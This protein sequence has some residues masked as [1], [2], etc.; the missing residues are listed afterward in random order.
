MKSI[1]KTVLAVTFFLSFSAGAQSVLI[2]L[3]V[4]SPDGKS[5]AFN[6]QGDIWTMDIT[7]Q[8][9]K[10]ITIHEGYDTKPFWSSTGKD[11][12]FISNRF[13]ND[14]IFVIGANGG[15][16]KR[17]TYHSTDD[18]IT[19]YT[20]EG[21]I[22]FSTERYYSQVEREP[23]IQHISDAGGTPELYLK[24]L[25]FDAKL[26]PNGKYVAFVRG[27]CRI[28]REAYR[29][30]AN[31]DIWLYD[32]TNDV[33]TQ[34]TN[35]DG[36]DFSP[37]W[38]DDNTIYFQ[39]SRS[40]K[41]NVHKLRIDG[42]G[43][44]IDAISAITNFKDSGIFSFS[45]SSNGDYFACVNG[46]KVFVSETNSNELKQVN[47]QIPT[48]YRFA[49]VKHESFSKGAG[50]VALSPNGKLSAFVIRGELFLRSTD[51][52]NAKTVNV[53]KSPYR[54]Q[55][56][57]WLNDS[58]IVFVSDRDGQN[59]LYL[60]KSGDPSKGLLESLKHDI[61][62]VT[63]TKGGE[64]H[65][66]ISP[67]GKSVA[68][69]LGRGKLIV[70]KINP[71]GK[72][73]DEIVLVDGWDTPD[74]VSWSP[75]SKWLAY[76]L[77]DLN[78]NQEVYIHRA[79]NRLKPVNVSMHP[80]R[81]REPI[82]SDDGKKLVFSSNRNNN[83]Y[84][85][86]FIWLNKSDS[87]KTAE[88]WKDEEINSS[89]KE[90]KDKDEKD[91]E[92]VIKPI[93]IDF[94]NIH[95][96]QIQVTNYVGGEFVRAISKDGKT[97]Y[98]TTGDGSR[99]DASVESDLFKIDW[100]G[101]N[102]KELTK[103]NARPSSLVL[104][105]KGTEI[106]LNL[107]SG[108][109]SKINLSNDKIESLPYNAK[110]DI[111]YIA[112]SEQIFEEAWKAIND[113]FYDPN[114]HGRDWNVLKEAYKPL[115]MK[116]STRTD[117]QN[118]FNWM[119]GQ[120]NASHMG[121]RSG[122]SR[123]ELE[124]ERT[125]LLGLQ[126]KPNNDGS[127]KVVNVV[128]NMPADKAMS[129]I[130]I[131]DVITSLNGTELTKNTNFYSLLEGTSDEKIY[132]ELIRNGKREEVIIRPKISNRKE[133]YDAWIKEQKRLTQKYS[134]G[135]L[136]YIHIQGMNWQSFEQFERELTAAGLGKEGLVIDVRY[137]GGGWTTDYLMA[138]LTVRQHAYTIPRG[139]AKDL[140]KE[141][142]NFVNH[143]PFGERL[144]LASWTKPS[145]AMCNSSSYSNAEIF[146][147][148][149]KTL[150]LGTLVG[151]PTFGA[152]ISTG[153]ARLIDGSYVRMP[154]RGWYVKKTESNMELGPAV[155]DIIVKK[156]PDEKA[157]GEDSQL[158]KAVETLLEQI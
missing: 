7:G 39:S 158:K 110:M 154:Y 84:D 141:N 43:K 104:N 62:R 112:E 6:Y 51:K 47:V 125:G 80:K 103:N 136:G 95:N 29:G 46:D 38:K 57:T 3:P 27:H 79:D 70:A 123:E 10:R 119:L 90:E 21:N 85:V 135:R 138:V 113:G 116:A 19:D 4:V 17:L 61:N 144:P 91:N 121:F 93:T 73:S 68:Y 5:V 50:D 153:S 9:T 2:N 48:D 146:S 83:D 49:P 26:S 36:N 58:A 130:K 111:D 87:E 126:L 131:G 23:E 97:I 65:P 150:G 69:T 28:A 75:D 96:R 142:K 60:L 98:Y 128:E 151:E 137:N 115:V 122:E 16:P 66:V 8:N 32:I 102:K 64:A 109:L 120:I 94:E 139:A 132:L 86:W 40:G 11:I 82:W 52:D 148:A 152:V 143:Y 108:G 101:K 34:L 89:E 15:T 106:V 114:F 133:N 35:Y 149:Y 44:K 78:F 92:E 81:D 145:I 124:R 74:D 129:T 127:V 88:D 157:K 54:D 134:N 45:L 55:M 42:N 13:G 105:R 12:A 118:M 117:F 37:F 56:P 72:L 99:G 22:L 77:R 71:S 63:K 14:D 18:E 59:D 24:S 53:S 155:P 20:K 107:S 140:E 100:D 33:Y 76:T 41:Y 25:G 30:P 67:D 147:H 156:M 1:L 31:R